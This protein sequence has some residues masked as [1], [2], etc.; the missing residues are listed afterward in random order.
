MTRIRA[1][2]VLGSGPGPTGDELYAVNPTR[3]N[4]DTAYL[5]PVAPTW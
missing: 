2:I 5:L 4:P 1:T 3:G